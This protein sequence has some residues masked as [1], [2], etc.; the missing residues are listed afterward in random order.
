MKTETGKSAGRLIAGIVLALIL[1]LGM[2][3]VTTAQAID[4]VLKT[5][6]STVRGTIKSVS[7]SQVKV[8]TPG[9]GVRTVS[10][11]N[12]ERM[13]FGDTTPELGEARR[14][15]SENR[16]DVAIQQGRRALEQ[17]D[18]GQLRSFH[19]PGVVDIIATA[20]FQQGNFDKAVDL[21]REQF[22]KGANHPR[23]YPL[24]RTLVLS[25]VYAARQKGADSSDYEQ[26]I[27]VMSEMKRN[28]SEYGGSDRLKARMN[29]LG[30]EAR[31]E[32]GKFEPARSN[33]ND[34]RDSDVDRIA[35][36]ATSGY[37]RCSV[38]MGEGLKA[39]IQA[40]ERLLDGPYRNDPL[41]RSGYLNAKGA[42]LQSSWKD[43]RNKISLLRDALFSFLK[44]SVL[45]PTDPA[46]PTIQKRQS[47]LNAAETY[48]R[49]AKNGP[50]NASSFFSEQ[51]KKTVRELVE[52]Y[53]RTPESV[54][55]KKQIRN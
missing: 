40:Y 47:I 44:A 12:V 36:L 55:A 11:S 24:A 50:K 18:N 22:S 43:N 49:L 41:I 39:T 34:L 19:R 21:I 15:L 35:R 9:G 7:L 20:L 5:D 28:A 23:F 8:Q 37:H 27:S 29:L 2:T 17:V 38:R 13:V 3:G 32:F 16:Y 31:E 53:P 45:I 25:T 42:Q 4:Q 30:A 46:D 33:Y 14:A 10:Q 1:G 51:A 54:H 52:N 26:V 48:S 6:N